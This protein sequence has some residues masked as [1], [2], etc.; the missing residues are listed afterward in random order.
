M[1]VFVNY[2]TMRTR[3]LG[4]GYAAS[5]LG[6]PVPVV[7]G[8]T[9]TL[10]LNERSIL[11]ANESGNAVQTNAAFAFDAKNGNLEIGNVCIDASGP[12]VVS[13]K[14]SNMRIENADVLVDGRVDAAT[15]IDRTDQAKQAAPGTFSGQRPLRWIQRAVMSRPPWWPA[16]VLKALLPAGGSFAGA[17]AVQR[18]NAIVFVPYD[19][20]SIGLLDVRAKSFETVSISSMNAEFGS[21]ARFRGGVLTRRGFVVLVPWNATTIGLFDPFAKRVQ[22]IDPQISLMGT[23]HFYGGAMLADGRIAL[24]PHDANAVLLY[25]E[26]SGIVEQVPLPGSIADESAKYAGAVLLP[27]GNVCF[28]PHAAQR[29]A[30]LDAT[31]SSVR[32]VGPVLTGGNKFV[33]GVLVPSGKI[34]FVPYRSEY[35]G[36]FDPE[37]G[38][39]TLFAHGQGPSGQLFAGGLLMPDGKVLFVPYDAANMAMFDPETGTTTTV[40]TSPGT[41]LGAALGSDGMA[42]LAPH[43]HPDVITYGPYPISM[44]FDGSHPYLNTSP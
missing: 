23:N 28:V 16:S 22:A 19:A 39:T 15:W 4:N 21:V 3:L 17:V 10:S 41:F 44:A 34:V 43:G 26:T 12:A 11:Y 30:V 31:G 5:Q 27:S 32:E 7:A 9:G 37:T 36:V 14:G 2:R 38:L 35:V 29:V 18:G 1:D 42:Y 20:T 40:A 24:A 8:G 25:D 6:L 13:R 33:G